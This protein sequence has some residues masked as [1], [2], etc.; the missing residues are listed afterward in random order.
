MIGAGKYPAGNPWADNTYGGGAG[1]HF[2]APPYGCN[3]PAKCKNDIDQVNRKATI[4]G[5]QTN[6]VQDP[7]CQ[8]AYAF[9][10]SNNWK[11]WVTALGDMTTDAT[12]GTLPEAAMCWVNNIRDMINM[13]NQLFWGRDKWFA[14]GE[15]GGHGPSG[16]WGW[17]EVPMARAGTNGVTNPANWDAVAIKMPL[18]VCKTSGGNDHLGCM[19]S[20]AGVNLENDL[21]NWVKDKYMIPGLANVGKRPGSYVVLLREYRDTNLNNFVYF[22]CHCWSSPNRKFEIVYIPPTKDSSYG[23]CYLEKGVGFTASDLLAEFPEP[24]PRSRAKMLHRLHTSREANAT[25]VV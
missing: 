20:Q 2:S 17:N 14:T 1:C 15:K 24:V 13:Q 23:A 8:C 19:T 25:L 16:Y 7:S 6:L 18:Y 12:T 10:D 22:F 4:N 3:D 5:K 11:D 9:K 21:M